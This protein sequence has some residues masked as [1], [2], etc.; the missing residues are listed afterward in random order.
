MKTYKFSFSASKILIAFFLFALSIGQ[1]AFAQDEAMQ[2]PGLLESYYSLKNALVQSNANLA[3]AS[4]KEF[5]AALGA[6]DEKIVSAKDQTKLKKDAF[7]IAESNSI[8]EQRN[9][10]ESL[11]EKMVAI[12][13]ASKLST[14]PV[15]EQY[16]PM[17]KASWL[18]NE[19]AIKNPYYGNAML[20]CGT[21][22]STL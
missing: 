10:F 12:A 7:A 6:T 11:S 16:C 17:K 5:T 21:V 18:S 19:S 14:E 13:H 22:K 3:A 9:Q 8:A 4:A 2:K 15:Y 1:P 20:K